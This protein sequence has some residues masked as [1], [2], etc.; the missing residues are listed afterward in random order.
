MSSFIVPIQPM[1]RMEF[2]QAAVEEA[3]PKGAQSFADALRAAVDTLEESQ[4]AARADGVRLA[5]GD[6]DDLA[7][8][9][10]NTMKADSMLQ[11]A[12][13]RTTRAVNAYK[14]IM[15]MQI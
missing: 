7:Q 3:Q 1:K 15:Q 5:M 12:V 4:Q 14:E 10:I 9:Q 2:Q 11:T 6:V 13:Q 8:L